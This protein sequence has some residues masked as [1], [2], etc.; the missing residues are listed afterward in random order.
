MN[1]VCSS[2]CRGMLQ[3][4][5]L[6]SC[7]FLGT[8]LGLAATICHVHKRMQVAAASI[9]VIPLSLAA[10]HSILFQHPLC[11]K[12]QHQCQIVAGFGKPYDAV[13]QAVAQGLVGRTL[14]RADRAQLKGPGSQTLCSSKASSCDKSW[15]SDSKP[16]CAALG[17][18]AAAAIA[19]QQFT[20]TF[21][22][23]IF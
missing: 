20:C 1:V 22:K 16:R 5:L 7:L 13:H 19:R 9:A 14:S 4:A 18:H 23:R 21:T 17:T 2:D 10:L 11:M 15:P 12:Q 3:T 8:W 6:L